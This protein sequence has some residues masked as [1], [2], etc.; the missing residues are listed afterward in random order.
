M[1]EG[2]GE[3]L[4]FPYPLSKQCRRAHTEIVGY[5]VDRSLP[6]TD[7][8]PFLASNTESPS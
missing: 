2:E 1:G 4:K 8:F 5:F 6:F 7:N 3:I